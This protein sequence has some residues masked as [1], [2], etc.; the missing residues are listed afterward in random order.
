[1]QYQCDCG[2]EDCKKCHPENCEPWRSPDGYT[3]KE[4]RA[5]DNYLDNY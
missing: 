5:I 2:A 3:A 1:M 4:E